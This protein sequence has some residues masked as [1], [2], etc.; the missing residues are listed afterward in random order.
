MVTTQAGVELQS[1]EYDRSLKTYRSRYDKE[2]TSASMAVVATLSKVTERC[3]TE[4]KPLGGA[5][6][7]DALDQFFSSQDRTDGNTSVTFTA[8]GYTV[9]VYDS[10]DITVVSEESGPTDGQT[11]RSDN[12]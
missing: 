5:I 6:D 2:T 12:R 1:F 7:T 10:A 11:K 3:P 9:T 8:Q 4:L